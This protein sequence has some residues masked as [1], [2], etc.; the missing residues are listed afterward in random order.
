MP[1]VAV[2]ALGNGWQF[3]S[4]IC[5]LADTQAKG[6]RRGGGKGGLGEVIGGPG[7]ILGG[8]GGALECHEGVW[9]VVEGSLEGLGGIPRVHCRRASQKNKK[10]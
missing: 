5:A 1:V 8:L 7:E 2:A 10:E 3:H 4:C 6:V 9:G